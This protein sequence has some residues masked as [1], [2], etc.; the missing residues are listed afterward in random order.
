ML[1]PDCRLLSVKLWFGLLINAPPE[2]RYKIKLTKTQ[3]T[4]KKKSWPG[5]V[6][7]LEMTG[8]L[9]VLAYLIHLA[10]GKI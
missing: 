6:R 7:S 8:R 3:K 10:S 4:V 2:T 1:L 5:Q 9:Q